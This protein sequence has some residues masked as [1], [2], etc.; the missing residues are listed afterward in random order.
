MIA[1]ALTATDLRPG[2]F[3]PGRLHGHRAIAA[4]SGARAGGRRTGHRYR[5]LR[6]ASLFQAPQGEAK[7]TRRAAAVSRGRSAADVGANVNVFPWLGWCWSFV[8]LALGSSSVVSLTD[9]LHAL[10]GIGVSS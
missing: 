6:A 8:D 2:I 5:L 7:F 3:V 1:A 10:T 4:V 9:G